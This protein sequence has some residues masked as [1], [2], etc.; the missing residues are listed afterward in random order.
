MFGEIGVTL[1]GNFSALGEIQSVTFDG[2]QALA[3]AATPSSITVHIQG[4]P[5]PGRAQVVII[6]TSGQASS[7]TAFT[8]DAPAGGAPVTWAAFGASLTMGGQSGGLPP[9]GQLMSWAAQ[10]ARA[11]GV[12]LAP[13]LTVDSFA[14][15]LAPAAFVDNCYATVD[16][17]ALQQN[18]LMTLKDPVTHQPDLRPGRQDPT[19][20]TR[21]FS[22][23]GAKVVDVIHPA[24]GAI[25][26]LERVAEL[27]DGVPSAVI[28]PPLMRSQVDRLVALDPDVAMSMDLLFNDAQGA[29]GA[30]DDLRPE[31]MTPVSVI[32]SELALLVPRLGAL[33]GDYFIGNL[34]PLD[35]LPAV[36]DIRR[37]AIAAG[38][39]TE[40]SFDAKIAEMRARVQEY[41]DAL[42]MAV[43]P[44]PNLRVVDMSTQ[45]Q[46]VI[47][48]GVEIGGQRLTGAKFGGLYS[49]D[50]AHLTDTGYALI[51]NGFI[52]AI[53][54]T[55][56]LHIPEVDVAAV[57]AVDA[58]SPASLAADGVHCPA[59]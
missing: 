7:D 42:E 3:I 59:E 37:N 48:Q 30:P 17:G 18:L 1:T 16:T 44:Y 43:T 28:G 46:D 31:R 5:S 45:I 36:A 56:G 34:P 33:H 58:L 15:G 51:A 26:I 55:M 25:G 35:V 38:I 10:V 57:L 53:N 41:N 40:A 6:G 50:F 13:P 47:S 14:P 22:V 2:I 9:H 29:I 20:A 54:E 32:A 24:T 19:L 27:P 52:D 39:E 23:G 4:A 49:L 8:Y 12:F 21:N 11:A